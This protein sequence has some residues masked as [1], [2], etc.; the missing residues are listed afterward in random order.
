MTD[1]ETSEPE[2]PAVPERFTKA[3]YHVVEDVMGETFSKNL[4]QWLYHNRM[5]MVRG[6][7]EQGES[8]FNYEF[9]DVDEPCEH[10]AELK[11]AL[12]QL[13][14]AA[15]EVLRIPAFDLEQIETH[16][17]LYHHG[18]HFIWH[19][20]APGA[21][22]EF[23]ASRRVAYAY[24]MRQEQPKPMFTG[25]EL[26]F[27]DGTVIEPKNNRLCMFYPLQQH[28]IRQ[29]ECYSAEVLHGRWALMGWLH[30]APPTGE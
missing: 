6:G 1:T 15:L 10:I 17:T 21:D 28:R 20:D 7:D 4:A 14:P 26:E 27:I 5:H 8:R 25:G 29:V 23:V 9:L 16:A 30:G 18:S 24:Y 2:A 11:A 13:I 19:D 22:G 12:V 3:R